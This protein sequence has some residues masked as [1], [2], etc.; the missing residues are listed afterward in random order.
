MTAPSIARILRDRAEA[1]LRPGDEFAF[2][3]DSNTDGTDYDGK[4]LLALTIPRIGFSFVL[5]IDQA[6]YPLDAAVR[7]GNLLGF[8]NAE[9]PSAIERTKKARTK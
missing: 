1:M 6:E 8:P 2:A 3:S 7:L 5:Q 4:V 9:K